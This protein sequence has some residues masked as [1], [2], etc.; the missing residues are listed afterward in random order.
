MSK[1]EPAEM[2]DTPT[3]LPVR[4]LRTKML[5]NMLLVRIFGPD[6]IYATAGKVQS[7]DNR[8]NSVRPKRTRKN[9]Q[10]KEQRTLLR[11]TY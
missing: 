8:M 5:S 9:K 1:V 4:I 7:T 6:L 10:H 2:E 3:M 11:S